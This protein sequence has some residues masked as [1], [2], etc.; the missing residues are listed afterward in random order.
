MSRCSVLRVAE[1]SRDALDDRRARGRHRGHDRRLRRAAVE[2]ARDLGEALGKVNSGAGVARRPVVALELGDLVELAPS[3][4]VERLEEE[5]RLVGRD[6]E[7]PDG[8]APNQVRQLVGQHPLLL[9]LGQRVDGSFREADLVVPKRDGGAQLAGRRKT[10]ALLQLGLGTQGQVRLEHRVFDDV[11]PT[12]QL[13]AKLTRGQSK[14]PQREHAAGQ[15]ETED[16]P[17]P[18]RRPQR[19]VPGRDRCSRLLLAHRRDG[20]L[21]GAM[22]DDAGI[23]DLVLHR[24]CD[25]RDGGRVGVVLG[26]H[27]LRHVE[28]ARQWG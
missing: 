5:H 6:A 28:V 25:L 7:T 4:V 24:G 17:R 18:A 11:P 1:Q 10:R 8:I 12:V 14:S 2:P 13:L 19:G 20:E 26:D 15:Y 22:L 23:D 21:A 9:R 27:R 3:K 16:D